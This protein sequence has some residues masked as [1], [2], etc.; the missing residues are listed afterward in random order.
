MLL[1]L[2]KK[3]PIKIKGLENN[4]NS[5]YINVVIQALCSSESF[6][7]WL[8]ESLMQ[9]ELISPNLLI[10]NQQQQS[11]IQFI[12]YLFSIIFGNNMFLNSFIN[13]GDHHSHQQQKQT[14]FA[15]EKTLTYQLLKLLQSK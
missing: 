10:Y 11:A 9:Q 5:C 14:K 8:K 3:A 1:N 4:E 7:D 2:N 12:N 13:F 15:S 6:V